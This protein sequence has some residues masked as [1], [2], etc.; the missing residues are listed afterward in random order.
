[1]LVRT[2]VNGTK[3]YDAPTCRDALAPGARL[4]LRREP[5]NPYDDR[6]IE[7]LTAAGQKLGYVPRVRNRV[8]AQLLDA[9]EALDTVLELSEGQREWPYLVLAVRAR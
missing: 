2:H 5:S 1:V 9:G 7:V 4:T 3:H 8:L 6:A